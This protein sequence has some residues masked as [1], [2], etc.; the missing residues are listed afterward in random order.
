MSRP[1]EILELLEAIPSRKYN[2][3][4]LMSKDVAI[5][6][7]HRQ[8]QSSGFNVHTSACWKWVPGALSPLPQYPHSPCCFLALL[9]PYMVASRHPSGSLRPM[10]PPDALQVSK[11]Y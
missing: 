11:H 7:A 1:P 3:I 9:L 6:R 4:V 2:L 5:L 10:G 8:P